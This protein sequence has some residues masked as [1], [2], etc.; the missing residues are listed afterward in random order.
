[1]N[2]NQEILERLEY[3]IKLSEKYSNKYRYLN[4]EIAF[5][6]SDIAGYSSK[7]IVDL[8][9]LENDKEI[10]KMISA[11]E[12]RKN[13]S[14]FWKTLE[15]EDIGLEELYSHISKASKNFSSCVLWRN[16]TVLQK[17]RLEQLKYNVQLARIIHTSYVEYPEF[18]ISW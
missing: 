8:K 6:L 1:M 5:V 2:K 11:E 9:N 13:M 4:C 14:D 18:L 10:N 3:I 12:A 7:I 17:K 15:K 16:L